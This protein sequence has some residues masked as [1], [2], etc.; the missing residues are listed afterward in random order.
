MCP[1]RPPE[2]DNFEIWLKQLFS[3]DRG[4]CLNFN[5]CRSRSVRSCIG[6]CVL[7]GRFWTVGDHFC[8]HAVYQEQT[9]LNFVSNSCS[10]LLGVDV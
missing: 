8:V 2:T 1:C 7:P 4:G 5:L 3:V 10:A 9:T 6:S